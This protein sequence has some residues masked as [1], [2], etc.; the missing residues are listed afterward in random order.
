LVIGHKVSANQRVS[1]AG[2]LHGMVT[3]VNGDNTVCTVNLL[4]E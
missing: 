3:V 1:S 4:R 2:W